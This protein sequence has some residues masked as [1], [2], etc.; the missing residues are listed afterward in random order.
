MNDVLNFVSATSETRWQLFL[1]RGYYSP[2]DNSEVVLFTKEYL[3]D[4]FDNW[5]TW[6]SYNDIWSFY[7]PL[8]RRAATNLWDCDNI[9][10]TIKTDPRRLTIYRF[11]FNFTEFLVHFIN[12][13]RS[14]LSDFSQKFPNLDPHVEVFNLS[15]K[16]YFSKLADLCKDENEYELIV[17]KTK[18]K[19]ILE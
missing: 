14:N 16:D 3:D 12:C 18:I 2:L 5:D 1:D 17:R 8:V 11:K 4:L 10:W 9:P 7:L 15:I 19:K 6:S 13:Y